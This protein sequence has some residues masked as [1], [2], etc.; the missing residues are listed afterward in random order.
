MYENDSGLSLA[1]WTDLYEE[2]LNSISTPSQAMWFEQKDLQTIQWAGHQRTGETHLGPVVF[3]NVQ[4]G[5]I[6]WFIWSNV[7]SQYK[8][9]YDHVVDT[10]K[11]G[12][13]SPKSLAEIYGA[14]FKTSSLTIDLQNKFV[15]DIFARRS[16]Q[17]AS[18]VTN[19]ISILGS[20]PFGYRLPFTGMYVITCGLRCCSSHSS[21][22]EAIDYGLPMNTVVKATYNG[23]VSFFGWKNDTYG[24]TI[25][26]DHGSSRRSQY[27][28]LDYFMVSSLGE[29]VS[30]G[31]SIASSGDTGIGGAHLHFEVSTLPAP[32]IG[33]WVRT[34][35]T[36]T[37][38]SGDPDNPCWGTSNE[39]DGTATGP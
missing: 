12:K 37:W 39:Y 17:T 13:R 23:N 7:D 28:H 10:L 27:S 11:F 14:E 18:L 22:P 32:G 21:L 15:S 33:V 36:T 29:Y 2:N 16:N 9:V 1:Q 4:N 3:T 6:V 19:S 5:N 35:P 20:D 25:T 38:Y 34:L 24:N 31:T 30:K 8:A 26:I